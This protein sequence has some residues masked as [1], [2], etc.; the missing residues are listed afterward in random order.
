MGRRKADIPRGEPAPPPKK[1]CCPICKLP[2]KQIV[3]IAGKKKTIPGCV[4]FARMQNV[5]FD[6]DPKKSA[7]L[8]SRAFRDFHA[9]ICPTCCH[10][11]D[12][13]REKKIKS[14]KRDFERDIKEGLRDNYVHDHEITRSVSVRACYPPDRSNY[15]VEIPDWYSE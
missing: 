11:A 15:T 5:K 2:A 6:N 1:L 3:H 7:R 12:V 13:C 4:F 14:V 10:P 9:V 8:R